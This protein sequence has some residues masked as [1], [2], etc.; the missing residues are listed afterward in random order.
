MGIFL[1]TLMTSP[2]FADSP[3]L[4]GIH[5]YGDTA[6]NDVEAM[7]GGRGV[8]VLEQVFTDTSDQGN[9]WEVPSYKESPWS[10]ITSKGHT[11][12]AR[13]HPNWGRAVPKPGDS[14]SVADY[15]LD[16]VT[17]AETLKNYCHIWQIANEMNILNEY[18]GEQLSPSY[19]VSV[20][21]QVKTAIESVS[22]PPWCPKLS[23]WDRFLR[24]AS[25]V[26]SGIWMGINICSRC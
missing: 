24:E 21:K 12:I 7:S 17:A 26:V 16:C 14:Y 20:Y 18:G 3:W 25:S 15:I 10:Q 6:Q 19:Y 11:I 23:C 8:Y 22:S 5:W 2:L 4:Y 9:F 1:T 13:L